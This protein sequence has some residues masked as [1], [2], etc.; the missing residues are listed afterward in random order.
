V[1]YGIYISEIIDT[2][3]VQHYGLLYFDVKNKTD[4]CHIS[5]YSRSMKNNVWTDW[6]YN[7]NNTIGARA[8]AKIQFLINVTYDKESTLEISNLSFTYYNTQYQNI[9]LKAG[10]ETVVSF[11]IPIDGKYNKIRARAKSKNKS[12]TWIINEIVETDKDVYDINSQL[13]LKISQKPD[14]SVRDTKKGLEK[15]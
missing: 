5:T 2:K 13:G 7:I 9:K 15:V 6:Y 3:S 10:N 8:G 14:T 11:S 1:A 12:S 4:D